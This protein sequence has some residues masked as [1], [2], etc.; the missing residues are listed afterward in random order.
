MKTFGLKKYRVQVKYLRNVSSAGREK[1]KQ[2]CLNNYSNLEKYI[3]KDLERRQSTNNY[4]LEAFL[5]T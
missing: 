1:E 2:L 4:I 5:N 3:S